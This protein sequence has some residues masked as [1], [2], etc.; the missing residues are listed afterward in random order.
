MRSSGGRVLLHVDSMSVTSKWYWRNWLFV[1]AT[2]CPQKKIS[3]NVSRPLKSR[4]VLVVLVR[5]KPCTSV[6]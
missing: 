4:Y 6:V 1:E 3:A 5:C 2:G